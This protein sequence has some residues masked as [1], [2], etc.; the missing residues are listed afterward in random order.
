MVLGEGTE[1]RTQGAGRWAMASIAVADDKRRGKHKT[2]HFIF[3]SVTNCG[4][5]L[6]N[7]PFDDAHPLL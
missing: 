2:S 6:C 7:A 1:A 5:L 4:Y 3:Q